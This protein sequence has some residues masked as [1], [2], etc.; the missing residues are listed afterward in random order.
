MKYYKEI[1]LVLISVLVCLLFSEILFRIFYHNHVQEFVPIHVNGMRLSHDPVLIYERS[2]DAV[3]GTNEDGFWSF[4]KEVSKS[5]KPNVTRIMLLGDSIIQG[6]TVSLANNLGSVLESDLRKQGME[7]EVINAGVAGYDTMQEVEQ[8]KLKGQYYNPDILVI[9]FCYNDGTIASTE[10]DII[11]EQF[12]AALSQ[13]PDKTVFPLEASWVSFFKRSHLFAFLY[14][15]IDRRIKNNNY[16]NAFMRLAE[17]NRQS[18]HKKVE[19]NKILNLVKENNAYLKRQ[20]IS[21]NDLRREDHWCFVQTSWLFEENSAVDG[22]CKITY[23]LRLLQQMIDRNHTKVIVVVFPILKNFDKYL[24]E[25]SQRFFVREFKDMGFDVIDLLP[26]YKKYK[27][28]NVRFDTIHPNDLGH[29]IA[30]DLISEHILKDR[31]VSQ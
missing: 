30:G 9:G 2:P 11:N 21:K 26:Y 17:Q 19:T 22:W 18:Y 1:L 31:Y 16:R 25:K 14:D 27:L 23:A 15:A 29:K 10:L 5:K 24:F 6:T 12:N 8:F 3:Q 20:R 4:G 13:N 28:E 7:A